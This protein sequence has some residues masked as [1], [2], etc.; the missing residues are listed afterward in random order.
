[1]TSDRKREYNLAYAHRKR[2]D[3]LREAYHR[4]EEGVKLCDCGKKFFNE[5]IKSKS[6]NF[7]GARRKYCYGCT[8]RPK[9]RIRTQ[10]NKT[11][12]Q[13]TTREVINK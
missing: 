5:V 10:W 9:V 11:K 7:K 1:M 6:G 4:G 8:E 12:Q 13:F 2:Q 3:M